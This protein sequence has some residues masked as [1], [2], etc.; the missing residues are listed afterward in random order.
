MEI[1][2]ILTFCGRCWSEVNGVLLKKEATRLQL[3]FILDI[4]DILSWNVVLKSRSA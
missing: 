4:L 3:L 2:V 1:V